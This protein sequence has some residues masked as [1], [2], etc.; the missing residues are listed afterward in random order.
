MKNETM[1]KV[2]TTVAVILVSAIMMMIPQL[3]HT[4]FQFAAVNWQGVVVNS[5]MIDVC[6]Y[7]AFLYAN[8]TSDK[9]ED[10]IKMEK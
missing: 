3:I 10:T 7:L 2:S 9:T 5:L 8:Q 1:K 6:V 4:G